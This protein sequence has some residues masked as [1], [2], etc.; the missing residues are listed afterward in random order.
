[1]SFIIFLLSVL[2]LFHYSLK[3]RVNLSF[4]KL[5]K[6]LNIFQGILDCIFTIILHKFCLIRTIF[7]NNDIVQTKLQ[8]DIRSSD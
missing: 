6:L 7:T 4:V 1:M 3:D 8:I 5:F 2:L